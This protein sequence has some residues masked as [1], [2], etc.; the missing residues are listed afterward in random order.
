MTYDVIVVGGGS[1][2]CIL[3]ARLAEDRKRSVLLLEAGPDYPDIQHLP[4]DLKYG[5]SN[6]A[7]QVGAPHNWSF[8]GRATAVGA[9]SMPVPRGKVIGGSGAINGQIFIRGAAEDFDTWAIWGNKEWSFDRVLPYFRKIEKDRDFQDD[10]HGSQGPLPVHRHPREAWLPYQEAFYQACL[11]LGFPA[12]PDLNRPWTTGVGPVPMNSLDGLRMSTALTYLG[13]VRHFLNLTVRGNTLVRRILFSSGRAVGVEAESGGQSFTVG[14]NEIVL[15]AGAIGSPQLL[16]LSGV[17]P[18][19]ELLGLGIPVILDLPGVGQNLR[20][21]PVVRIKQHVREGF[22]LDPSAPRAQVFLR[23]TAPG[24]T[25]VNDIQV[26][27]S[28]VSSPLGGDH[29]KAEGVHLSCQLQLPVGGGELRLASNDPKVQPDLHYRYFDE[30]PD[31]KRMREAV[32]KCVE[33]AEHSAFR[34]IVT[35]RVTPTDWDMAS[36]KALDDWLR[37]NVSTS[38]HISGTCMMGPSSD[39]TAVVDEFCRVRGIEGLRVADASVMPNVVR[40]N[41][42]ATTMMIA[43]RVADWLTE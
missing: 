35:R 13:P 10:S 23:F 30:Y 31:R 27:P 19:G 41:T 40:S 28:S 6:A 5:Y 42:H 26:I 16:M 7:H 21:H 25:D 34:N 22:P 14:G 9:S 43:E 29:R 15:G 32:R 1:A 38:H 8:V 24:S 11:D 37:N 17:G 20:D 12:N 3:G 18:A 39:I 4:D 33:M 36:D 2:G